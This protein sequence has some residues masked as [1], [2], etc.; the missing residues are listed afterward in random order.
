MSTSPIVEGTG[1]ELLH[2]L[3]EHPDDRFRLAPLTDPVASPPFHETAS[4]EEWNAAFTSWIESHEPGKPLLS[5]YAVS[6]EGIY[7][8]VG[9]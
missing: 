1:R 6:R 2:I 4:A 8:G 9:E 7:E 5:D 3:Q